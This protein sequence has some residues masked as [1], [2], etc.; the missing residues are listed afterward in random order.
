MRDQR[1]HERYRFLIDNNP[2]IIRRVP[3]KFIAS[4]LGI[5]EVTLSTIK[6]KKLVY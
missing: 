2:D 1:A 6:S 4:Y 3:S 5:T